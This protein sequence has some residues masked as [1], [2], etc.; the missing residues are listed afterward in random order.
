MEYLDLY[1]QLPVQPLWTGEIA[2]TRKHHNG[3]PVPPQG[4]NLNGLKSTKNAKGAYCLDRAVVAH[5]AAV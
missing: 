4:I 5:P 3:L 1:A 2:R